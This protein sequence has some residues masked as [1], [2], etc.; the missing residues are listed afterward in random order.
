[1]FSFVKLLSNTQ[2]IRN[3]RLTAEFP[4]YAYS[5]LLQLELNGFAV[6]IPS[7]ANEQYYL[8]SLSFPIS[9]LRLNRPIQRN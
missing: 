4:F 6:E 5:E 2:R 1:M 9:S 7:I 3:G 8:L